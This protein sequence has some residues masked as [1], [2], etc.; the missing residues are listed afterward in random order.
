MMKLKESGSPHHRVQRGTAD[1]W[2][3]P[4]VSLVQGRSSQLPCTDEGDGVCV[5]EHTTTT[6]AAEA[7][8]EIERLRAEVRRL[9]L[10]HLS[11]IDCKR[12]AQSPCY[13][14]GYNGAG[15]YQPDVH[16]CA[17]AFH[18]QEAQ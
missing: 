4:G 2:Q 10:L 3:G 12:F 8:G 14:C 15:Y 13:I 5:G 1:P 18:E 6:I 17:K 11:R 16:P 9:R 7:A